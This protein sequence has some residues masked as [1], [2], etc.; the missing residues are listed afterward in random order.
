MTDQLR[1]QNSGLLVVE[2]VPPHEER[3]LRNVTGVLAK[4]PKS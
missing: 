3:T 1:F 2:V 4:G